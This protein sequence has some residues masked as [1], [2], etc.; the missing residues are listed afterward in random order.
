MPS[1]TSLV[2]CGLS[3]ASLYIWSRKPPGSSNERQ[4]LNPLAAC[5]AANC[6]TVLPPFTRVSLVFTP[7]AAAFAR[8]PAVMISCAFTAL[9]TFSLSATSM[10]AASSS[11]SLSALVTAV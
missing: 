1:F 7:A 9:P 6:L 8:W 2:I 11:A 3:F 4:T 5:A 10:P